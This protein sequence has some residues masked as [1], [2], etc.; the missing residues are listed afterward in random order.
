MAFCCVFAVGAVKQQHSAKTPLTIHRL[1]IGANSVHLRGES[2]YFSA[3]QKTR[4]ASVP[5]S[6]LWAAHATLPPLTTVF[7]AL[8]S[9][10]GGGWHRREIVRGFWVPHT[11][12]LRVRG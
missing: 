5:C 7:N 8:S 9:T 1:N 6:R 12:G 3:I 10:R 11:P 4:V 2:Y